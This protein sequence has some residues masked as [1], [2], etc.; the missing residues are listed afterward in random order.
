VPSLRNACQAKTAGLMHSE[1]AHKG[2]GQKTLFS[3]ISLRGFKFRM[4]TE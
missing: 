4:T 3:H 2:R 1:R